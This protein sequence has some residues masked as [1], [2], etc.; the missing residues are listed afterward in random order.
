MNKISK[1]YT[2]ILIWL[3]LFFS[4]YMDIALTALPD[5]MW[6]YSTLQA[7]L[8]AYLFSIFHFDF[9]CMLIQKWTLPIHV[10]YISVWE[11]RWEIWKQTFSH[12]IQT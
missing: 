12:L 1:D 10:L 11:K 3:S 7:T 5:E 9:D 6:Y 8:A 4:S 2:V